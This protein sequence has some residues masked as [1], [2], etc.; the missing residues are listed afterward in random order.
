MSQEE[1]L[2]RES[3]LR[4]AQHSLSEAARQAKDEVMHLQGV[5]EGQEGELEAARHRI[6][7]LEVCN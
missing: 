7:E 6:L 5:V 1:V 4:L 2:R 3:E